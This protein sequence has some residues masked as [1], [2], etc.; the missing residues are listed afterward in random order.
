M[1][2]L[3]FQVIIQKCIHDILP[4]PLL[5]WRPI[6]MLYVRI[7][8]FEKYINISDF[9][10]RVQQQFPARNPSSWASES[11]GWPPSSS[12]S[13][14]ACPSW[15]LPCWPSCPC[16]SSTASSSS[17]ACH[18]S[19]VLRFVCNKKKFL[20]ISLNAV[21]FAI[22]SQWKWHPYSNSHAVIFD[23]S[24]GVHVPPS[25]GTKNAL[26]LM[27]YVCGAPIQLTT[28]LTPPN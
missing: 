13:L 1:N 17:W 8:N 15:W 7:W 16:P 9:S 3:I 21:F 23:P 27:P 22:I 24:G 12:L 11:R 10:R 5:N 6:Y 4:K 28:Y 26:F 20:G 18:L 14:P 19:E 2:I 25:S